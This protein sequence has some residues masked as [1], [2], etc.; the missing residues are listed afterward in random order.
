MGPGS[1]YT[2]VIPNLLVPDIREALARTKVPRIYVCNIMTEPGETTGYT[3]ADHIRAIDKICGQPLF[4]AVLVNRRTPSAEA[5]IRYA[6]ENSHPVFLDRE[7]VGKL[8]R[9]IVLTNIMEED[10]EKGYVRHD[11]HKLAKVL[12]KWYSGTHGVKK[13]GILNAEFDNHR[14]KS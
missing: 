8:G 1:L 12:L 7:D 6:Q 5:L 3:V 14:V 2:S 10:S 11:S 13:F 9:R 4:D